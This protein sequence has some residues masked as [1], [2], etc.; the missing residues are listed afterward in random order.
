MFNNYYT[1]TLHNM[2]AGGG[3]MGPLLHSWEKS[4]KDNDKIQFWVETEQV[5]T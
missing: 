2:S 3:G 4:I 5:S 1:Y